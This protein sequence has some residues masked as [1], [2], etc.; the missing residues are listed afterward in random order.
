MRNELK[1]SFVV[2]IIKFVVLTLIFTGI[3]YTATMFI[4]D[5]LLKKRATDLELTIKKETLISGQQGQTTISEKTKQFNSQV[6]AIQKV[7]DRYISWTP[8]I[9]S[10]SNLTPPQIILN[11][12][13]LDQKT[14]KIT[15]SGIAETREAYINYEKILQK[16]DLLADVIFPLQTKKENIS[17]SIIAGLKNIPKP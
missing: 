17:F 10:F 12:I 3:I 5:N 15:F 1:L 16:S 7:Q 14:S 6:L 11:S 13:A 4:G 8:I 9:N 2:L